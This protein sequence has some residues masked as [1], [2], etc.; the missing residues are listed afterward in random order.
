MRNDVLIIGAGPSGLFATSGRTARHG[1]RRSS[2]APSRSWT[3]SACWHPSSLLPSMSG[4]PAPSLAQLG[5]RWS[6]LV[7]ISRNPSVDPARAGLPAGGVVMVR[8]DG[9]IGFR[10][11]STKA[12]ALMAL[13]RHLSSYLI[14][15]AAVGPVD[16][17]AADA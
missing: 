3:P 16:T 13:D 17:V 14:P 1:P 5:R 9:H 12:D 4:V 15:D 2:P 7:E 8:P 10:H 11:P 6:G